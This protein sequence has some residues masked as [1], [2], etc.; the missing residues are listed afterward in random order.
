MFDF[1]LSSIDFAIL[2]LYLIGI[3]AL[4]IWAGRKIHNTEDFFMGG[5]RFRKTMMLFFSFGA[6]THSDQAVSVA[7]KTYTNGLSGIWYQWLWLFS[8]PFYWM[9]A[10]IFR[11]MR[12]LTTADYFALRYAKSVASLFAF[13]GILQIIV[14]MAT[15]LKGSGAM[16][17]AVTGGT[18]NEVWAVGIMTVLFVTYGIV[19]GLRAAILTDFIQ[20]MLTVVLSFL[21]LPFALHAVGGMA[22]LREKVSDP[23]MFQLIAPGDITAFYIAVISINALV[24]I[25][26]QP[27][28]MPICAA[29]KT[30]LD[31]RIGFT[32]GNF[33]KRICTV[34]WTFV[35]LC[36]I[37]MFPGMTEQAQIDQTFGL[38]A[39]R[40]LPLI[41]P[42]LIGLFLA[43]MLA[44]VMSTCDA[45]MISASAL[46]TENI[47]KPYFAPNKTQTHYVFVGR[48]VAGVIV[49]ASICVTLFYL[50]GVIHGLETFWIIQALMGIAFWVGLFWRRATAAAA[51]ASTIAAFVAALLAAN[52]F[53][54]LF[55]MD[56]FAV[57]YLPS[58]MVHDGAFRLPFQMLT[59]LI[60]GLVTIVVV[61]LFTRRAPAENLDRLYRCLRTPIQEDETPR[62]PFDYPTQAQ[63]TQAK[64]IIDHPDFELTM[65]GR[66]TLVGFLIAWGIVGLIIGVVYGIV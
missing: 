49:A 48:L 24:G 61:S 17:T 51:W 63:P 44:A 29:G 27:H 8:T 1:G 26:T 5:R 21:L 22:G 46:F 30:E 60:V 41:A 15:M 34:A 64:K 59:Y 4:G 2:G 47:Y 50:E 58:F 38:M 9:I 42:G 52:A 16:I 66:E 54:A 36:A 37:A 3:T 19:G 18:V 25:V 35:G 23:A 62:H 56:R 43:S 6:G 12:A 20:G 28:V 65:P 7:A 10:P 11:R 13:L 14:N 55:D 31:N 53:P 40:L 32:Y 57:N 39:H 33:L 45:L